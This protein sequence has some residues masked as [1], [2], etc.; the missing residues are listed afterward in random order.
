MCLCFLSPSVTSCHQTAKK[1]AQDVS[2]LSKAAM[3]KGVADH[4]PD[5]RYAPR[6]VHFLGTVPVLFVF[7]SVAVPGIDTYTNFFSGLLTS[8]AVVR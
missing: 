3:A 7:F 5:M 6:S 4:N 2:E 1:L 8:S